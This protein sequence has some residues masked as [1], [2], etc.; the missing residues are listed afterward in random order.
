MFLFSFLAC[1]TF[2]LFQE[3]D[4]AVTE[5]DIVITPNPIIQIDWGDI[6]DP[7]NTHLNISIQNGLGYEFYLGIIEST[8]ECLIDPDY[9]CWT[10]ES[11]LEDYVSE[12]LNVQI[13]NRCHLLNNGSEED[14]T[15]VS[16]LEFYSGEDG[17]HGFI[18]SNIGNAT[19]VL[20]NEQTAFT[21]PSSSI[22]Y[23]FQVTYYLRAN[24]IGE[25]GAEYDCWAWGVNPN[26]YESENCNTPVP[27]HNSTQDSSI[28][29]ELD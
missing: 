2:Y 4:S 6:D 14:H 18:N 1:E 20:S 12:E 19:E 16:E 7:N 24:I 5:D 10:G 27:I 21:A 23:E 15:L 13:S 29:I 9:G 22:N 3:E 28:L 8:E 11:C 17:L 26:F 25:A